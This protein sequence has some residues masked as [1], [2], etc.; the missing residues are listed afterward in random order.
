M[1]ILS[2]LILIMISGSAVA[3]AKYEWTDVQYHY[4]TGSVPPPYYFEYD[5][6]INSTGKSTLAYHSSYSSDSAKKDEN[7][8]FDISESDVKSLNNEIK[9]SKVL[10][11]TFKEMDKHP[12]GGSLQNV[13]V[14]LYQDPVIDHQP[15]RISTPYFPAS[16]KQKKALD[17]LYEKIKSL[18]PQNIWDDI[19]SKKSK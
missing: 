9:K 3:Q 19:E 17:K 2:I 15:P 16:S 12:I 6:Y 13:T 18:V 11:S 7:Y 10:S 5:L 4:Q 14:V 8:S 1:K